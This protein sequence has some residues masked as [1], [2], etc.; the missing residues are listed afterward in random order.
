M[1]DCVSKGVPPEIQNGPDCTGKSEPNVALERRIVTAPLGE[2]KP[3]ICEVG[4][5][6]LL[7]WVLVVQEQL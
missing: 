4:T 6:G 7:L 2:A 5:S 1:I 3:A